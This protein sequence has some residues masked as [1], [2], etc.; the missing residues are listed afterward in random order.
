MTLAADEYS[1]WISGVP[2]SLEAKHVKSYLENV[3]NV[4]RAE[5]A[6]PLRSVG[7]EMKSVLFDPGQRPDVDNVLKRIAD[8]LKGIRVRR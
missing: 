1:I 6:S 4:A 5:F 8:A 7:I 2:R 3:R